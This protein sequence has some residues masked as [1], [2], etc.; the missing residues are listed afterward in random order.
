MIFV[1]QWHSQF[2][3]ANKLDLNIMIVES[4]NEEEDLLHVYLTLTCE[5]YN[6]LLGSFC[7]SYF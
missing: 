3:R 4:K 2:L 6:H 5:V 1:V 7:K